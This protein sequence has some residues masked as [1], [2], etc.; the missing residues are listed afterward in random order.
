MQYKKKPF[1]NLRQRKANKSIDT[2]EGRKTGWGE[3]I[4]LFSRYEEVVCVYNWS[5]FKNLRRKKLEQQGLFEL[6]NIIY[7]SEDKEI[8]HRDKMI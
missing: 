3:E 2:N 1:Q 7:G 5:H 4:S 8:V 6:K